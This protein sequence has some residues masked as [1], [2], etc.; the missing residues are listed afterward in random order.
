MA[1]NNILQGAGLFCRCPGWFCR[2]C[3][4]APS[5]AVCNDGG[6]N[7]AKDD[8]EFDPDGSVRIYR[9]TV[10][11]LLFG[12]MPSKPDRQS[13][14]IVEFGLTYTIYVVLILQKALA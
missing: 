12:S 1:E 2:W 7:P 14:F 8:N 6:E 3:V 9:V 4:E 11:N 10:W 5:G 13:C